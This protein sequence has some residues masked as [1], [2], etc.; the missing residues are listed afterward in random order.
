MRSVLI[1]AVSCRLLHAGNYLPF[2][3]QQYVHYNTYSKYLQY[4]QQLQGRKVRWAGDREGIGWWKAIGGW[5]KA[6]NSW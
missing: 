5:W 2:T 3:L 4:L 6:V 1:A